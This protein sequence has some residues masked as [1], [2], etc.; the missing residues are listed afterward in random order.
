MV[1]IG[2]GENGR[3]TAL[4][5]T[6][7]A[8]EKGADGVYLIDHYTRDPRAKHLLGTYSAARVLYPDRFIGLNILSANDSLS[9]LKTVAALEDSEVLPPSALWVDDISRGGA[10]GELSTL[11]AAVPFVESVKI[12]GGVAFKYTDTYTDIPDVAAGLATRYMNALDVVV[13]SGPGTGSPTDPEKTRA[14]KQA[15]GTQPLAVA[16]GIDVGNVSGFNGSVDEVLAS[17]SIE[18][19]KYSGVFDPAKL[20]ELIAAVHDLPNTR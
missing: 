7:L 11:K 13:T 10:N 4:D 19:A 18:T 14:M 6:E 20:E 8:F 5:Q 17:S 2:G 12:L 3:A 9:A 15:V 1:H 16:S